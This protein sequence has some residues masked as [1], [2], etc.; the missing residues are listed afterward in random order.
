MCAPDLAAIQTDSLYYLQQILMAHCE[1]AGNRFAILD[2][3]AGEPVETAGQQWSAINGINGAIYYPWL[4]VPGPGGALNAVPP[5]AMS[6]AYTPVPT[7]SGVH[8]APANEV[9]DGRSDLEYPI[10]Q[11]MQEAPESERDQLPARISRA[12]HP[13]LGGADAGLGGGLALRQRAACLHRHPLAAVADVG[14][15]FRTERR[16]AVGAI[17]RELSSYFAATVSPRGFKRYSP[18]E[19]LLR[20]VRR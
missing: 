1:T 6:P 17:E 16:D 19:R 4:Q 13:R 5:A 14:R 7:G 8:K 12:R 2:P 3:K 20:E 11:D 10:N 9:L 15:G 18:Q